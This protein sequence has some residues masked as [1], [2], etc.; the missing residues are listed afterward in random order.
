MRTVQVVLCI[1]EQYSSQQAS[2]TTLVVCIVLEYP[3]YAQ[4]ELVYKALI[5]L[6]LVCILRSYIVRMIQFLL[7][8]SY[9][10]SKIV[11]LYT[12]VFSMHTFYVFCAYYQLEYA[13]RHTLYPYQLVLQHNI[14]Q[15]S[16][17]TYYT[18]CIVHM[19]STTFWIFCFVFEV[20]R[21]SELG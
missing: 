10:Q 9:Y 4:Y 15:S 11:V 1:V 5:L 3:Y 8:S 17:Y 19:Y 6:Q 21:F 16:T 7:T 2:S 13:Y 18:V 12:Y 14:L 20:Y